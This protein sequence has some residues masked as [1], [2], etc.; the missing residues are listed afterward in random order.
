M[1]GAG[2]SPSKGKDA[3]TSTSR[4]EIQMED[5]S[6]DRAT[7]YEAAAGSIQG[8]AC[9]SAGGARDLLT[10]A[11]SAES[12]GRVLDCLPPR[13]RPSFTSFDLLFNELERFGHIG[14]RARERIQNA[15]D[16]QRA[17]ILRVA[18][19]VADGELTQLAGVQAHAWSAQTTMDAGSPGVQ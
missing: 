10:L 5:K 16:L 4:L 12:L 2:P 8:R 11:E 17:G 19:R 6:S 13:D 9:T 14:R 18:E 15:H 1:T 3:A 7:W